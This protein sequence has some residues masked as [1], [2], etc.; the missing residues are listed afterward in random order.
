MITGRG[1]ANESRELTEREVEEVIARCVSAA[2][3]LEGCEPTA[4]AEAVSD[5]HDVARIV[6]AWGVPWARI[7]ERLLRPVEAELVSRYGPVTGPERNR[8]FLEEFEA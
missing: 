3:Y 6:G 4:R 2:I 1:A 5:I 7:R 8:T